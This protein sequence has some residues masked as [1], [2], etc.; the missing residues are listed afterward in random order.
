MP[1]TPPTDDALMQAYIAGDATAFDA[2][3]HR[4][5]VALYRFV[6]R[7]LGAS[8]AAHVDEV[9]QDAWMRLVQARERW[10][11]QGASFRTWLF[12]I[13]HH[14][15]IDVLRRSG[16]E[17][18]LEAPGSEDDH[19]GAEPWT[20]AVEPWQDWPA[21]ATGT[22]PAD[23]LAFWRSAGR[24][25][26]DCLEQLPHAQRS[27]FLLHHDDGLSLAEVATA[28]SVGFETARTRLRYAMARLRA[29]M[30]AWLPPTGPAA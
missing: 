11:P 10:Q 21:P 1:V 23:D 29:C 3:Y 24:R 16:R 28:L 19:D 12:S 22:L 30:G 20:P 26:L 25:L 7:L 4:H 15:A 14:R 27:A 13:A 9:Y 18:S 2:L 6:R 8:H 17:V 5:Q